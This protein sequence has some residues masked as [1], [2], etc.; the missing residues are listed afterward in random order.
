MTEAVSVSRLSKRYGA[1]V[2]L[3]E[4][5]FSVSAGEI[6]ALLGENGAG[7]STAVKML[8]GLARP[9]SGTITVFGRAATLASPVDAQ[10]LGLQT[11]FQEMTL[12]RDLTVTQNILLRRE[13]VGILGQLKRSTARR[14]VEEALAGLD[15]DDV[16]PDAE[17]RDLPLPVRQKIEIAK[18][19]VRAPR[20]LLLDEATSTLSGRDLDWLFAQMRALK[21]RGVT[22]LFI[23]H[24]LREIRQMCD[25]LTILRNGRDVGTFDVA[26]VSDEEVVGRIIGRPLESAFPA[27]PPPDDTGGVPALSARRLSTAEGVSDLSFDLRKG[28]ILGV[29]GLQGMGQLPLFQSCFGLEPITAGHLEVDGREVMLT[30]PSD[31]I[32]ARIGISLLPEDRKSEGLFLDLSGRE[33]ITLPV[34]G[35]FTRLGV[36]DSG[37]EKLAVE[38]VLQALAVHP[39]ALY[40]PCSSFSGGNQ[41][42]IAIAKW[43]MAQSRIWLMFDPTR[44]VDVGTKYEIYVLMQRFV[45]SGGAVLLYSSDIVELV[46]V[47]SRVL[48]LYQGR[49][50]REFRGDEVTEENVLEAALGEAVRR[51]PA[52]MAST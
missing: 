21:A 39:R 2:A 17:V 46:N 22:I 37:R 36:V 31:A 47:C 13:P 20:I 40:K 30:S 45:Q 1:T 42:K 12:I 6:H 14:Q 41:Q 27:K 43:I 7:K 38:R 34:V 18:A 50:R 19:I 48:V 15:L 3:D 35:R 25:R 16:D 9:D 23:S 28:E 33:N 11:A 29:A 49:L 32:D 10:A 26:A 51:P 4:A 44:G 8:S 52:A 5:S 24:R